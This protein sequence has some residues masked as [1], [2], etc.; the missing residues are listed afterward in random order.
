MTSRDFPNVFSQV[1]A[2]FPMTSRDFPM[3]SRDFPRL[4]QFVTSAV[5]VCRILCAAA[6]IFTQP[7]G[8]LL[9]PAL[10]V[11]I[12]FA[13]PADCRD[14]KAKLRPV[15]IDVGDASTI[16]ESAPAFLVPLHETGQ[17]VHKFVQGPFD[18]G[19]QCLGI[20]VDPAFPVATG[21]APELYVEKQLVMILKS[22]DEA[23]LAFPE[24]FLFFCFHRLI[25]PRPAGRSAFKAIELCGWWRHWGPGLDFH[26]RPKILI[27]GDRYPH[28]L[29]IR[30]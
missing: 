20:H 16:L 3:T 25:T 7:S 5:W 27:S 4:P 2:D 14:P 29:A 24:S 18:T 13:M 12:S 26:A 11:C 28:E 1:L 22:I 17:H 19:R 30:G 8:F 21:Q 23:I 9:P 15:L 6:P 10:R